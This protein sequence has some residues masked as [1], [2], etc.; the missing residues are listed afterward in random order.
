[1]FDTLIRASLQHRWWVL[2]GAAALVALGLRAARSMP[3]DVLPEL[4]AP[5][6]TVITEAEGL[7]P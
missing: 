4:N 5:T 3:V 1:M 7:A 6:V 2:A